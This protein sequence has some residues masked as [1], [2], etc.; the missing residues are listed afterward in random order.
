[1][2]MAISK[3]TLTMKAIGGALNPFG[4]AAA[5]VADYLLDVTNKCV[6]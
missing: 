1:M 5:S 2:V 3:F 6:V 4:S